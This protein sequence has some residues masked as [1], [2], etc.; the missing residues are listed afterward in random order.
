MSGG[1]WN[2]R[3][4]RQDGIWRHGCG[5]ARPLCAAAPWIMLA[6]L[7][8]MFTMVEGRLVAAPGVLFN[9]PPVVGDVSETTGFAAF[10]MPAAQEGGRAA[11]TLVLFDDSRYS[12]SEPGEVD[13]LRFH[14]AERAAAEGNSTLLLLADRRLSAGDVMRLVGIARESGVECVQV[15]EKRE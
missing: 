1:E 7:F 5:W 13:A 12:L 2:W 4:V 15:A 14:L 3:P 10:A 9:L 6:L 11:E 8:V